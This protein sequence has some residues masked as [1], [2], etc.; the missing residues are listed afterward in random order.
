MNRLLRQMKRH[1]CGS[2][3]VECAVVLPLLFAVLA[4]ALF[5]GRFFWHYTVAQKAA[6]DAAEFL[7]TAS[8]TELQIPSP[9]GDAYVVLA[10]RAV[11]QAEIAELNPGMYVPTARVYCDSAQCE[12]YKPLPRMVS[13]H[14][15]MRV[16]DPFLTLFTSLF[17]SDTSAI[18]IQID[19]TGRSYYVGN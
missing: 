17:T 13:V 3:A 15:G 9:S 16:D 4:G 8:P 12:M 5:F 14:V 1:E 7:A 10:A 19:A 2:A 18:G 11:A 6:Q